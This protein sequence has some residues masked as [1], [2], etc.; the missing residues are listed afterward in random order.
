[1]RWPPTLG[2]LPISVV[3]HTDPSRRDPR[4]IRHRSETIYSLL[5]TFITFETLLVCNVTVVAIFL[6]KNASLADQAFLMSCSMRCPSR[7][8]T[9]IFRSL[10]GRH[11]VTAYNVT[12]YTFV[13]EKSPP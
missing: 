6:Q 3:S 8:E 10:L 7:N 9:N 2:V 11:I 13:N 5:S 1:M 12:T 4:S